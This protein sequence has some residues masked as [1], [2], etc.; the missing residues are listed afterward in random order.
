MGQARAR[1]TG[2][3][4]D[5]FLISESLMENVVDVVIHDQ[6]MGSDHCPVTLEIN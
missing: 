6:V 3:R 2:W 4:L 1:N 5:Y